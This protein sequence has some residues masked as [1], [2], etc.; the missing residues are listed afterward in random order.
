MSSW[1]FLISKLEFR[2]SRFAGRVGSRRSG[3][4]K[5]TSAKVAVVGK[6]ER[7]QVDDTFGCPSVNAAAACSDKDE[8]LVAKA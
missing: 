3:R 5:K 1:I 8:R 6:L 2:Q 4:D 7:Q